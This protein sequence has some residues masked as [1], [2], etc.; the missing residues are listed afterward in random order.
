MEPAASDMGQLHPHLVLFNHIV[1]GHEVV[2]LEHIL[3]LKEHLVYPAQITDGFYKTPQEPGASS[4]L[5]L[6]VR[7]VR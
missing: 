5:I 3:H 6:T 1:L 2:F 4:D 7:V